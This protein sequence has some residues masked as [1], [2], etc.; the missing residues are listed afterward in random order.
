MEKNETANNINS[1]Y[2]HLSK[3]YVCGKGM[4][5]FPHIFTDGRG[6][7]AVN[8]TGIQSFITITS[9]SFNHKLWVLLLNFVLLVQNY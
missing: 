4:Y 2:Y 3:Y 9:Y 8:Y 7:W 6:H 5:S 1:L